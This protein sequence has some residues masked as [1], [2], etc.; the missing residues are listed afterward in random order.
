[1][2]FCKLAAGLLRI[3]NGPPDGFFFLL[4]RFCRLKLNF[5]FFIEEILETLLK[6]KKLSHY[7]I[8]EHH[9]GVEKHPPS[10]SINL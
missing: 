1:M 6:K 3:L 10:T 8:E 5:L 9:K 2:V 4:D 7:R